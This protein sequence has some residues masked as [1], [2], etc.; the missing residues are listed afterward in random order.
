MV[1]RGAHLHHNLA[2]KGYED[3]EPWLLS[4]SLVSTS[5][6][7]FKTN[8]L[9]VYVCAYVLFTQSCPVLCDLMDY[10]PT[11]SAVHG[12][13]QARILEWVDISSPGDLL[14]P[15]IEPASLMSSALA[16]RLFTIDS[17][18]EAL[19]IYELYFI[20]FSFLHF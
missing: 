13:L 17:T 4:P 5:A 3:T 12:I 9:V 11:G 8:E 20:S 1:P 15:G 16:G 7:S 18:W 19:N 6:Y 2:G 14:D 10:S